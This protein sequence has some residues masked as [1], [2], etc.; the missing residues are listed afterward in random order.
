[1]WFDSLKEIK[2]AN[3][4]NL[5]ARIYFEFAVISLKLELQIAEILVEGNG[6]KRQL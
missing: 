5:G 3:E 6:E 1:M 2:V 4:G